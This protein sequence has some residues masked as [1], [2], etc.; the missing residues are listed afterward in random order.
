M[1]AAT[2]DLKATN[3]PPRFWRQAGEARPKRAAVSACLQSRVCVKVNTPKL[4]RRDR[5]RGLN[6]PERAWDGRCARSPRSAGDFTRG[7]AFKQQNRGAHDASEQ[8]LEVSP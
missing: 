8:Q 1:T 3:L 2:S 7:A 6:K 5:I 4:F